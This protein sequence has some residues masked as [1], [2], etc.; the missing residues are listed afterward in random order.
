MLN[1]FIQKLIAN[2]LT[3][4]AESSGYGSNFFETKPEPIK[5]EPAKTEPLFQEQEL[6]EPEP[7]GQK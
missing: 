5:K 7:F 2:G 1:S 6:I 3:A 4:Q